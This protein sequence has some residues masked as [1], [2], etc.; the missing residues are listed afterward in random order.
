[1]VGLAAQGFQV[2]QESYGRSVG[3]IMGNLLLPPTGV[4]IAESVGPCSQTFSVCT[5]QKG[6]LEVAF[7]DPEAY[8]RDA[9]L[10]RE[11]FVDKYATRFLLGPNDLFRVP[12]GNS[13]RLR[14]YSTTQSCLLTWTIIRPFD[15]A[16]A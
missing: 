4:K 6:A 10:E 9:S 3:Y 2:A 15:D 13:Y 1:M 5:G 16:A 7:M 12:P 11:E 8:R 14:N